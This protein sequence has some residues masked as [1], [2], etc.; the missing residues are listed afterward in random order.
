M[1]PGDLLSH[2]YELVSP[3]GKGGL[4]T[5]WLA[6]DRARQTAVAIK[7][8]TLVDTEAVARFRAEFSTLRGLYHPR[9]SRAHDF[10][11]ERRGDTTIHYYSADY[12]EGATLDRHRGDR[13]QALVDA[14][15]ALAFLHSLGIRHGDFKAQNIVV[16]RDARGVLLDLS[17]AQPIGSASAAAGTPSHLAPELL[18]EAVADARADLYAVGVTMRELGI[19]LPLA[20]RLTRAD[21]AERPID[22]REVL[23]SLGAPEIAIAPSGRAPRLYGRDREMVEV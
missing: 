9:L 1:G 7:L 2:R 18:R 22:A 14:I 17:C 19:E 6:R 8:V 11:S 10:G 12:I 20:E 5:A 16:D 21:P 3:I 15:E 23:V 13:R 4:A